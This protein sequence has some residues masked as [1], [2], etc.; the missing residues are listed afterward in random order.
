[1]LVVADA[2]ILVMALAGGGRER[3]EV[4][5]WLIELTGGQRV[6]VLQNFTQLEYLSAIRRLSL[7]AKLSDDQ[8]TAAVRAFIELPS[9]R[10]QVTQPMALRIWEMRNNLT[11]YDAAYVALA[12]RLQADHRSEVVVATD[13]ARLARAPGLLVEVRSFPR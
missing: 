3:A 12:E 10:M 13:D 1:M 4:Q 8:A 5:Q 11:A 6:H 7:A 9:R 2:S